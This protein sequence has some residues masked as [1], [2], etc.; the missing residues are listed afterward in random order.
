MD[1]IVERLHTPVKGDCD[2]FVAGGGIAGVS[3]A[4]ASA[5]AGARTLLVEPVYMLGGLATAGLIT[6]YLPLCDGRGRQV[7]FG[8]S[9]ELLR[10][11]IQYGAESGYPA[12]WLEPGREAERA[13]GQRFEVQFNAQLFAISMERLLLSE[14]VEILYGTT[15]CAVRRDGRRVTHAI[16]ENQS[17]RSAVALRSI[18]DATGDADICHLAGA[19]TEVHG[20]GN[21]LAAWY[22][23]VDNR[24]LSL[25]KLGASDKPPD[26]IKATTP[27]PLTPERF[28]G[29]DGR[30]ISHMMALSHE[31]TLRDVLARRE[32]DPTCVPA[33]LATQPQLRMTRRLAGAYTL[34]RPE[35]H[36]PFEDSV[37]QI[38]DWRIRG[39][40]YDIP[41]RTLITPE[42][43][44]LIAA[45]RC[46]SVT[47]E[48]WDISRAIP[49][50]AVTGEAAG[51]AAALTDDFSAL[52][53]ERLRGRLGTMRG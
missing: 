17:G 25:G 16:I 37:G 1:T 24:G 13:Q 49:A 4:L 47:D 26:L 10:L 11:S 15:V 3:A 53:V 5:R 46:I 42:V 20:T 22:Y 45:G 33:T 41:F 43:R 52:D 19:P 9:E 44:N 7:S 36:T 32:E 51:A 39:P 27:P 35:M 18:V 48:M 31:N 30:E 34:D 23:L 29:L 6:Y 2:V 28:S 12:I 8:I 21:T 50:C 14:G 38:G 40:V